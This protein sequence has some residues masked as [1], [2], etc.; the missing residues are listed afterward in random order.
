MNPHAPCARPPPPPPPPPPR[1]D[2][3]DERQERD[4]ER[5]RSRYGSV[6]TAHLLDVPQSMKKMDRIVRLV[7]GWGRGW[8]WEPRWRG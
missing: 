2:E 3:S 8:G 5:L 4:K 7:G 1:Y 6:G